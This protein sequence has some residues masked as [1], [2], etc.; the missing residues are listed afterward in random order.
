LYQGLLVY[1]TDEQQR[2]YLPEMSKGN[3]ISTACITEAHCGSDI[4]N[5][6]TTATVSDTDPNTYVING[7]KMWVTNGLNADVF[8]VYCKTKERH[9]SDDYDDRFSFFLV[10]RDTPGVTISPP[11]STL[12][13]RGLGLTHVEFKDVKVNAVHHLIGQLGEGLN[14]L[15][16]L[17]GYVRTTLS[18]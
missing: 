6:Q 10:H 2:H 16:N 17:H 3:M 1:G 18:G 7:K 5:I 9:T 14:V 15:R 12:G 11:I 13:L 4:R 8:L